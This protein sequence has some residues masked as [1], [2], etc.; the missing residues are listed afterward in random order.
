MFFSV[1][2]IDGDKVGRRS[3]FACFSEYCMLKAQANKLFPCMSAEAKPWRKRVYIRF[4]RQSTE[5]N[6]R[7]LS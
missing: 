2:D 4:A 6:E 7:T 3:F 1:A 5:K